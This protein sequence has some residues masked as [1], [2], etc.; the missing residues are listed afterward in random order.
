MDQDELG[1]FLT[2][3]GEEA[4]VGSACSC[5]AGA[6]SWDSS[7]MSAKF[8]LNG[9][10]SIRDPQWGCCYIGAIYLQSSLVDG[11]YHNAQLSLLHPYTCER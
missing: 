7:T 11:V 6:A 9:G 3:C 8:S 10:I 5:M 2:A 1:A 4:G